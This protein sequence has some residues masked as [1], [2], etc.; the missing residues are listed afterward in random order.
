[1]KVVALRVPNGDLAAAMT[2]MREW[3]DQNRFEA[4]SFDFDHDGDEMVVK[5]GFATSDQ[6]DAFGTR[7]DPSPERRLEDCLRK[8]CALPA[9]I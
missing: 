9:G 8:E 6:A 3:L 7:F 5:V 4:A 1:M 2:A